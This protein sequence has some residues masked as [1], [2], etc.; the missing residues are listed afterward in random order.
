MPSVLGVS[1]TTGADVWRRLTIADAEHFPYVQTI[2]NGTPTFSSLLTRLLLSFSYWADQSHGSLA[3]NTWTAL[4]EEGVGAN[5][6]LVLVPSRVVSL[7]RFV[8]SC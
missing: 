4:S 6:Q 1:A 8:H 5:L 2:P 7:T 3:I